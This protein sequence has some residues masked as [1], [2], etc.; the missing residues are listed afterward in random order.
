MANAKKTIGFIELPDEALDL[1][2]HYAQR[3]NWEVAIVVS[4]DAQSYASRMAD[5]LKIPVLERPNRPA[6]V[7]CDRLIVG[8]K[9]GLMATVRELVEDT[10]IEV[11]SV[12]DALRDLKAR[13]ARPAAAPPASIPAAPRRTASAAPRR[14]PGSTAPAVPKR[15]PAPGKPPLTLVPKTAAE[16][17]PAA[18]TPVP[19]RAPPGPAAPASRAPA[20]GAAPA[21]R[22]PAPMPSAET[23]KAV[24]PQFTSKS[25]FDAGFLLGA[26]FREKLGSLPIDVDGDQLLHEILTLAIRATRADAG[27]IMLMDEAGKHLRIAVA[28]G[29]PQWVIAETRQEV[30]KG[31]A[32]KVFAT[33]KPQIVR[34]QLPPNQGTSTDVRPDLREAAC[35]PIPGKDGPVGVL[36]ITVES[37][38][39]TLDVRS[40]HLLHQFA[41]EA[42]GAIL[43][44]IRLTRLSGEVHHDALIRQVERL[45]S[46]QEPQAT[47]LRSVAE[48]I[49]QNLGADFTHCLIVDGARNVLELGGSPK[50]MGGIFP[51]SIPLDRGFLGWA[52]TQNRPA[53]LETASARPDDRAALAYLPIAG[54]RPAALIVMERVSLGGTSAQEVRGFLM[55]VKEVVEA[56]LAIEEQPVDLDGE[57]GRR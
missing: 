1:F 16:K 55:E 11:V 35:V 15:A 38:G 17:R 22:H 32:G 37:E 41:R 53:V 51:R 10:K 27:S 39:T 5:I 48:V 14:A 43:K 20:K 7:A 36:N 31:V 46:L 6:L 34:G 4:V 49:G 57:T 8:K 24:P 12:D 54:E 42:S 47:R 19:R 2:G 21:G 18:N 50:G 23:P 28:E 3:S 33:G 56:I 9:P 30:G 13:M 29:L 45:M 52:V 40:I 25:T 44:A 26:D